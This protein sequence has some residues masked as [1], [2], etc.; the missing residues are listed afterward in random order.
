MSF[1]QAFRPLHLADL[2]F[3]LTKTKSAALLAAI[4]E[5]EANKWKAIG[6]KVGK[7]AKVCCLSS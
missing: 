4:K 2:F 6:T 5:Y 1:S 7:P 3:W